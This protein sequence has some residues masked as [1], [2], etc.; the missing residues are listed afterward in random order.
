MFVYL[1]TSTFILEHFIELP[2]ESRNF[3]KLLT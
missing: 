1:Q 2:T 3:I